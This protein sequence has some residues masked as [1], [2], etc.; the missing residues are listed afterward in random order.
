MLLTNW[1]VQLVEEEP[2]VLVVAMKLEHWLEHW[3]EEHLLDP[4]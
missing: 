1:R 4:M 2:P 3:L